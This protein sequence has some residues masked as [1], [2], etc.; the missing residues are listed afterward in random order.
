[1]PLSLTLSCLWVLAAAIVAMLPMRLQYAP[2]LALLV[3]APPLVVYVGV[4]VGWV[5]VAIVVFA[6]LSMYRR[7]LLALVHYLRR[8]F[9]GE[10]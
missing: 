9:A 8:R 6:V 10:A 1:M 7:P 5:W 2:G 4:Q 3:L